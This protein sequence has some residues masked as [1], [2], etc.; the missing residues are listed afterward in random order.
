MAKIT[1]KQAQAIKPGDKA[2]QTGVTGLTLQPTKTKGRGKWNLRFV[3]PVTGKRRD[4]GMGSYPDVPVAEALT[5]GR[6]ARELIA[7]GIDPILKRQ[8]HEAIPTFEQAACERYAQLAPSF[9]SK[10]RRNW[11]RSLEMYAFPAIGSVRVDALTPQHFA[12][13]L[14]PIW[15]AK[16]YTAGAVKQRS[17]DVMAA[18]WA[19]G[20]VTANPLDVVSRLLPKQQARTRHFPA[21]P[22]REVPAFADTELSREH[23]AGSRAALLFLILTACRSGEVRGAPWS[24]ID[25]QRRLWIIPAERMKAGREHRVPLSDPVVKLLRDQCHDGEPASDDLIFPAIRGGMLTDMAITSLLRKADAPSD[26]PGRTAA[27]HGFRASF[28]N[29]AADH[30]YSTDIAERALA[31]AVRDQTQAAYERTDRL[32]AR[33]AMMEQWADHVTGKASADVIPFKA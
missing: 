20:H 1:N 7:A 17:H 33:I 18:C 24:E 2:K 25:L 31:H 10:R 14:S 23:M 32:D 9:R 3:S 5:Q 16:A 28:R 11:I 12:N 8:E 15:L 29:W 26:V 13:M 22:W 30:G 21:M 19:Q 27:A 4:M 6:K